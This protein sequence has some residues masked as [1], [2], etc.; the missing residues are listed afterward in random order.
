MPALAIAAPPLIFA[1][2]R[3]GGA[4]TSVPR[5]L[6]RVESRWFAHAA[7]PFGVRRPPERF[8]R[9]VQLAFRL[10]IGLGATITGVGVRG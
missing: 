10:L 6:P 1:F 8:A 3:A 7:L 4:T 2:R 5:G 9:I